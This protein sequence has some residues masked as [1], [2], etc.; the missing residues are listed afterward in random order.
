MSSSA[1]SCPRMWTRLV[2]KRAAEDP[3]LVAYEALVAG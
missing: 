3:Q 1:L 2:L